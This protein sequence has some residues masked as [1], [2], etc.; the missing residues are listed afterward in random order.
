MS[1]LAAVLGCGLEACRDGEGEAEVDVGVGVL[2]RTFLNALSRSCGSRGLPSGVAFLW[3]AALNL[4]VN[5]DIAKRC[6]KCKEGTKTG[7]N[8]AW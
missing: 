1:R 7:A 6:A 5:L 3:K 8:R 2:G 4:G